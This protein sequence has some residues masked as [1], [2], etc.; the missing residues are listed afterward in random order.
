L[1]DFIPLRWIKLDGLEMS[2][3]VSFGFVSPFFPFFSFPDFGVC[4]GAFLS[5]IA[6]SWFDVFEG[7]ECG[8]APIGC[9]IDCLL[10]CRF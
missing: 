8:V 10:S 1:D 2:A 5:L 6:G 9:T 7:G 4:A 3:V